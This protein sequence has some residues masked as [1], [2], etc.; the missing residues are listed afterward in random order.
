M[1]IFKN[2][3]IKSTKCKLYWPGYFELRI[4][5]LRWL[6]FFVQL[7]RYIL[8]LLTFLVCFF[9]FRILNIQIKTDHPENAFEFNDGFY[10]IKHETEWSD[11]SDV[12]IKVNNLINYRVSNKIHTLTIGGLGYFSPCSWIQFQNI[13]KFSRP[14][15]LLCILILLFS[16]TI[17]QIIYCQKR[18]STVIHVYI[19]IYIHI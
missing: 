16:P 14:S 1:F 8:S 3:N 2:N 6:V 17:L 5:Y 9:I 13:Q 11:T 18:P 10:Y 7:W 12:R 15:M 19:Y 4:F